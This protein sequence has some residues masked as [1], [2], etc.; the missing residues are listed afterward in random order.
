M[1]ELNELGVVEGSQ[2]LPVL[3]RQ[4]AKHLTEP[5]IRMVD[6]NPADMRAGTMDS[7]HRFGKHPEPFRVVF[8][9]VCRD[10]V[11][12][13]IDGRS[14]WLGAELGGKQP[15]GIDDRV[16]GQEDSV[17][18]DAFEHKLSLCGWC[19]GEMDRRDSGNGLSVGLLGERSGQAS[20]AQAGFDMCHRD[21][22][23]VRGQGT[24]EGG[25]RVPL[26]DDDRW[27]CARPEPV[28][29]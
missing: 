21:L 16:T 8:S 27:P 25:H 2:Y 9:A 1:Q 18:G 24:G 28:H 15:H 29:L 26:H 12:G 11:I 3:F 4:Q 20:A 22:T 14:G 19:G 5:A 6:N 23:V 10:D 17:G 7:H 13:L